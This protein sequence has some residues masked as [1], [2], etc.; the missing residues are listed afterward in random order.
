MSRG[1]DGNPKGDLTSARRK[2][3]R[4]AAIAQ[5]QKEKLRRLKA[6]ERKHAG[7]FLRVALG[8]AKKCAGDHGWNVQVRKMADAAGSKA[9][10]RWSEAVVQIDPADISVRFSL[11]DK[12]G[13]GSPSTIRVQAGRKL[14]RACPE[15]LLRSGDGRAFEAWLSEA[16]ELA[17]RRSAP[18]A[19]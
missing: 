13:F 12:R 10:L 17:V 19:R 8:P 6:I 1:L 11:G 7:G 14:I 15:E 16:L 9:L 2:K 4:R 5:A 18:E 3:D